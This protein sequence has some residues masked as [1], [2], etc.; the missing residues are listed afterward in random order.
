MSFLYQIL[1]KVPNGRDKLHRNW[2]NCSV[3]Q[4]V[5]RFFTAFV[6]CENLSGELWSTKTSRGS[7]FYV[8]ALMGTNNDN[9]LKQGLQTC[10]QFLSDIET[11]NGRHRNFYNAVENLSFKF[12]LETLDV[13]FASLKCAA[14]I[15]VAFRCV[16]NSIKDGSRQTFYAHGKKTPLERYKL[17][18]TTEKISKI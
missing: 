5:L 10:Q 18:P 1:N 7:K 2:Y 8:T 6:C 9:R 13:M 16:V 14:M 12:V 17:V 4:N 11:E 15:T 3:L